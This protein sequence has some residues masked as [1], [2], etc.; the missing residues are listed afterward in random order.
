MCSAAMQPPYEPPRHPRNARLLHLDAAPDPMLL[1]RWPLLLAGFILALSVLY[2]Y[3]PSREAARRRWV[4]WGSV[5]AAVL[6]LL[7]SLAFS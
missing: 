3:G 5:A 4:T 1:L 7:A 6:L 2:R